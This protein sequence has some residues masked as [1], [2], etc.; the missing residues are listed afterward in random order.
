MDE[1]PY[2]AQRVIELLSQQVAELTRTNA[3]LT[4]AVEVLSQQVARLDVTKEDSGA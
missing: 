4:S 2:N 3:V 1:I